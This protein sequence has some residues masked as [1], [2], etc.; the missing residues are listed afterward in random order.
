[1]SD[2]ENKK[3]N[4]FIEFIEKTT[5]TINLEKVAQMKT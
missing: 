4:G 2:L 3:E 1:M 5:S